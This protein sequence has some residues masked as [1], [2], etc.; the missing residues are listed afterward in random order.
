MIFNIIK[1]CFWILILILLIF[2]SIT[3]FRN[4][5]LLFSRK[6]IAV[7]KFSNLSILTS[8]RYQTYYNLKDKSET[9]ENYNE[10]EQKILGVTV[11]IEGLLLLFAIP[12]VFSFLLNTLNIYSSQYHKFNMISLVIFF[13]IVVLYNIIIGMGSRYIKKQNN[14]S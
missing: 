12:I 14:N 3:K 7:R 8:S 10:K 13:I 5:Y 9:N 1:M 4:S 6:K 11:T 2:G